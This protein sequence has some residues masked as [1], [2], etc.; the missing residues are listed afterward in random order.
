MLI[1]AGFSPLFKNNFLPHDI[2]DFEFE[3]SLCTVMLST[4]SL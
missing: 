2:T 3:F 4:V 1:S